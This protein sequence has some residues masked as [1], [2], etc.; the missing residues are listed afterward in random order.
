MAHSSI[1]GG[2]HAPVHP[3]GKSADMLGP[4]DSSDSGSDA[5]GDLGPDQL[6][7]DSDRAGTGERASVEAEQGGSGA[8]ILPDRVVRLNKD[9]GFLDA[10]S[11]GVDDL[12]G[13]DD[14]A[15]LDEDATEDPAGSS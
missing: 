15:D 10:D 3:S 12:A 4:S 6:S 2:E 7:S 11:D 14:L 9:G 13:M 1:L 5:R 8:D